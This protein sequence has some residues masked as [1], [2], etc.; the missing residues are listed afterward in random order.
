LMVSWSEEGRNAHLARSLPQGRVIINV[1]SLI[2]W[3]CLVLIL[4]FPTLSCGG[5]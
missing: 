4:D 1:S 5:S 3:F 2:W